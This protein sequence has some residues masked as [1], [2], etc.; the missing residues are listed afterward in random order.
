MATWQAPYVQPWRLT[1]PN[2]PLAFILLMMRLNCQVSWE[3]CVKLEVHADAGWLMRGRE[4]W[5]KIKEV[6]AWTGE[7]SVPEACNGGHTP[8]MQALN[9]H[10]FAQYKHNTDLSEMHVWV[11]TFYCISHCTACMFIR[12]VTIYIYVPGSQ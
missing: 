1:E 4:I 12:V 9:L 5:D 6:A 10:L 8:L 11:S 2:Q 3:I 7:V